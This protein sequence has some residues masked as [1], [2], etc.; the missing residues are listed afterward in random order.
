VVAVAPEE[1]LAAAEEL[2]EG[3]REVD[4]RNAASRGYYAA[5]HR[6]MLLAREERLTI[7]S[8]ASEHIAL[9]EG[10]TRR[11][12]AVPLRRLGAMLDQ[13]RLRRRKADYQI[14]GEFERYIADTVVN[15]SREI[16]AVADG[17]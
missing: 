14:E 4:W 5:Y 3:S 9:V 11:G 7:Q 16:L 1:I 13:C 6:C 10:L 2:A 8:A 15:D 17:F 12:N